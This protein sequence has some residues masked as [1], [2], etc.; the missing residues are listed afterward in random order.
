M[1]RNYEEKLKYLKDYDVS[2]EKKIELID[3][4]YKLANISFD[5]FIEENKE[6]E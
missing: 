5:M 1:P 6:S 4:L 2:D 3:K